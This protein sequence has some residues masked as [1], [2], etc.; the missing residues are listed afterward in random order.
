MI[1]ISANH[2]VAFFSTAS[3]LFSIIFNTSLTVKTTPIFKGLIRLVSGLLL[4]ANFRA[5]FNKINESFNRTM[6]LMD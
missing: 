1:P 3:Y 5:T 6:I 4:G 2:K